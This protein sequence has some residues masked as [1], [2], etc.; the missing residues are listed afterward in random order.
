MNIGL[1][2]ETLELRRPQYWTTHSSIAF[3]AALIPAFFA[4]A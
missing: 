2:P 1:Y 4:A 3:W